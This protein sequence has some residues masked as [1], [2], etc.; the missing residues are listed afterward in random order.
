MSFYTKIMK[1]ENNVHHACNFV[2]IAENRE[3][4]TL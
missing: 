3:F 2:F 1:N 4:E